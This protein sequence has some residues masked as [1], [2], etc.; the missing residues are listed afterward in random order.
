MSREVLDFAAV[1]SCRARVIRHFLGSGTLTASRGLDPEG[2]RHSSD[3]RDRYENNP[4]EAIEPAAPEVF[5]LLLFLF[6]N[7][8][9]GCHGCHL[10]P[11][12]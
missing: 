2:E 3:H 1:S 5:L 7:Q 9:C 4:E 10:A 11:P 12:A 8:V 6:L